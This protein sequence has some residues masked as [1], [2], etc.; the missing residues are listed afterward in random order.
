VDAQ[1]RLARAIREFEQA[2]G[3]DPKQADLITK[4]RAALDRAGALKPSPG[5]REAVR[6][7]FPNVSG[8]EGGEQRED[9]S[10]ELDVPA[11]S[12]TTVVINIDR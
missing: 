3:N 1:V 7:G 6:A 10:K 4:L 9:P 2:H 5:H 11:K 8:Q 12:G